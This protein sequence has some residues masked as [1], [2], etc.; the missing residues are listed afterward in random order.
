MPKGNNERHRTECIGW[1]RPAVL[2]ANDGIRSTSSL[3]LGVAAAHATH[4][5]VLV[6]GVA[7]LVAGSMSMAAGE[8]V[9]V[10]SQ[11]DTEQADLALERAELKADDEGEHKELMAIYVA[12]RLDPA[13]AKKVAEQLMAHDALGTHASDVL[14]ISE[15]LRGRP[16]QAC[17]TWLGAHFAW[18]I[19]GCYVFICILDVGVC[20]SSSATEEGLSYQLENGL[21]VLSNHLQ[22]CHFSHHREIDPAEAEAR[23]EHIDAITKRLVI[24]RVDCLGQ[25]F[26]A[27]GV[28]PTI[29]HFGM[30]FF[31]GHLQRRVGHSKWDELLPVLGAR[32]PARGF[33]AL[34][35]RGCGQRSEQTIV[36]DSACG[37]LQTMPER[38][39]CFVSRE[40]SH[41]RIIIK[42]RL[43][44]FRIAKLLG[45]GHHCPNNFL[46][47]SG[48]N[49]FA[50]LK[51][52]SRAICCPHL[53]AVFANDRSAAG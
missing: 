28:D 48:Q 35:E 9:S 53:F 34:V 42:C 32:E 45:S 38:R 51:N 17:R 14:G 46:R 44:P 26:G 24:Q 7:G 21:A 27:V 50:T 40:Y 20:W 10:R 39:S 12:R 31:N 36:L 15:T 18:D 8:Y 3:L 5:N 16:I 43:L 52:A 6:A 2:G 47:T 19:R 1:L 13:L 37:P 33:Q 23:K 29:F 4:S 25:R 11:A 30:S 22:P 41:R 49:S